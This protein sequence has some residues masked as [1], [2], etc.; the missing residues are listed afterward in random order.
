[1]R[2][3]QWSAQAGREELDIELGRHDRRYPSTCAVSQKRS[4][5][6]A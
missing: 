1:M 2:G 4:P 5:F 6:A 3:E